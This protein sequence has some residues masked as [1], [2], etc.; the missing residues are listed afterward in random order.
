MIQEKPVRIH[1]PEWLK[2]QAPGGERYSLI[3][4]LVSDNQLSTVCQEAKCP[5]MSE[6]WGGG[7]A[8]FMILGKT[9]TRGCRFCNVNTAKSGEIVDP[10]EPQKIVRSIEI[11]KLDYAVLTMV[12]RDDLQDGGSGQ[13]FNVI[14]IIRE[15]L[16]HVMVE[17]LAG[18]FRGNLEQVKRVADSNP[19]V[20]AHNI[21]TTQ[22]LTP[23]V[24]DAK[25]GYDQS[26]SILKWVK[27]NYP[28]QF[29]KSSIM[30]G[31]GETQDEVIR[32]MHDLR[33]NKVDIL[34]IG[35]YLQP[36]SWH[37][38]VQEFIHPDQFKAYEVIG[39]DLGFTYVASGPLV[40]TSYRAGELFIKGKIEEKRHHFINQ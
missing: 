30:V 17:M 7:T 38:P 27:T 35:Q 37:L 1:K 20:F 6:C 22:R 9:C 13:V 4:N 8:T 33:A 25:C 31:L 5:N 11:M 18:D 12:D 14:S 39:K 28:H 40:R 23:T 2:I 10:F 29:T 36:S 15:K 3:K 34:T 19:D 24:R 21:E 16:P 26:L 32:T